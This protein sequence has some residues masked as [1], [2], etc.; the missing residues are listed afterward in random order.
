MKDDDYERKIK[1]LWSKRIS[2]AQEGAEL[3]VDENLT[4]EMP[5]RVIAFPTLLQA[6]FQLSGVSHPKN[7]TSRVCPPLLDLNLF[8]EVLPNAE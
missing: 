4:L 8:S 6:A 3:L 1:H 5:T 7:S 2:F